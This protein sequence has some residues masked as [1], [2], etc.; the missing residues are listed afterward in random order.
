[1]LFLSSY[2][3]SGLQPAMPDIG[4]GKSFEIF[5]SI[6]QALVIGKKMAMLSAFP[7]PMEDCQ[8]P[9]QHKKRKLL[10][11]NVNII[12]IIILSITICPWSQHSQI[13]W[14]RM[15]E[16]ILEKFH[17][18]SVCHAGCWHHNCSRQLHHPL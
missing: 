8:L 4:K 11:S 7:S 3:S 14:G 2:H 10:Q 15:A 6:L 13:D 17:N 5:L 12:L 1:M 9:R 16:M 18:F